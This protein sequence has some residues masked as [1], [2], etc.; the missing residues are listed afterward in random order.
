MPK[1]VKILIICIVAWLAIAVFIATCFKLK[2]E[3]INNKYENQKSKYIS[4]MTTEEK[5]QMLGLPPEGFQNK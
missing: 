2:D 4:G 5:R 1:G 3:S